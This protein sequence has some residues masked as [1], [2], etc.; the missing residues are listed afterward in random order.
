MTF[1]CMGASLLVGIS[2]SKE[3]K[4]VLEFSYGVRHILP[5]R[6]GTPYWVGSAQSGPILEERW[7]T[8]DRSRGFEYSQDPIHNGPC[9]G[10]W[11]AVSASGV[12][13]NRPN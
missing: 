5:K 8:Y 10:V 3:V 11:H 6:S 9:A 2:D 12:S 4:I 7:G 13:K 1:A